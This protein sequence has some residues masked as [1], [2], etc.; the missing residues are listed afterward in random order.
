MKKEEKCYWDFK[1]ERLRERM[2][3]GREFILE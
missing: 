1:F 3:L 2:K